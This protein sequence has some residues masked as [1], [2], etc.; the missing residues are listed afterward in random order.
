[1][2]SPYGEVYELVAVPS[3]GE[4]MKSIVSEVQVG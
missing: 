4:P 1:M 3:R 2:D